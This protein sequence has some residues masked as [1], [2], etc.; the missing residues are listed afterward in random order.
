MRRSCPACKEKL[1]APGARHA[2]LACERCRAEYHKK[3]ECSGLTKAQVRVWATSGRWACSACSS[4]QRLDAANQPGATRAADPKRDIGTRDKL[5]ILQWNVDG[6][7]T[8]EV[9]LL[10]FIDRDPNI[11]VIL[12]QESKL[13][14]SDKTPSLPGYT[15]VRRDRPPAPGGAGAGSRGGGLITFVKKDIAFRPTKAYTRED[16][17]GQLEAQAVEIPLSPGGQFTVVN[18]YNP[19]VR[20]PVNPSSGVQFLRVPV[21][22][23]IVAGDFNAHSPLWDDASQDADNWGEELE[24][25]I[26]DHG[27]ASLNDGSATH[28]NRATGSGGSPDVTLVHSSAVGGCVWQRQTISGSDHYPLLCEVDVTP[29]CLAESGQR[30]LK[31]RLD[32]ADWA[33][34]ATEME[35]RVGECELPAR[36][37]LSARVNFVTYAMT[38]AARVHVGRYRVKRMGRSWI[39]PELKLATQRRNALGRR[40][41]DNRVAWLEACREVRRLSI[42]CKRESWRSYVERIGRDGNCSSTKVWGVIH[43]LSGKYSAPA[44]EN[45]MLEHRGRTLASNAR[46]A[47]AFVQHYAAVSRHKS[48][49]EDRKLERSVKERLSQSRRSEGTEGVGP[50][51]ADFSMEEM[52]VALKAGKK[53]GAEGP[54]E[55][56]PL[57]LRNLGEAGREYVLA[58]FNQSWREGVCPQSWRDACI[59]PLLKPGKPAG[60]LASYRP[61]A[62][63]SCLGKVME[64]MVS[65]RLQHLAESHGWLCQEQSGFRPQRSAEDQV[66]RLSQAVSDGFQQSP[67]LRTVLATLDFSKAYDMVWRADLYD[68]MLRKGVPPR[69]VRWLKGFLTNRQARVRLGGGVSK[70][71]LFREGLPQGSVLS[72]LLF[73]F[74][75]NGLRQRLP[76]G[77]E[78]SM[79]A[80]DVALWASHRDKAVAAAKVEE[81]VGVVF[82]WSQEKKLMLNLG[83]CEVSFFSTD[84][85]EAKWQPCVKVGATSLKFT[86]NPVFL[87][88]MYDRTLSFRPQAERTAA[89]LSKKTRLLSALAGS[90]WGWD[91]DLLRRIFQSVLL[92]SSSYCGAGWK[93]WAAKSTL[94]VLDKAQNRGLRR[95]TGQFSS[96]PI[97]ALRMEA[98]FQSADCYARRETALAWEKSL[99]LPQTH[100]RKSV[101]SSRVRHRLQR[102][103]W[104]KEGKA[105]ADECGFGAHAPL[106]LPP[107]TTASWGRRAPRWKV[108]LSLEG[109]SSRDAPAE[110]KC[111]D[112][113]TTIRSFGRRK[114]IIY[115]DGSAEGGV[116]SGGSAAII[117]NDDPDDPRVLLRLQQTGPA[118]TSSF[119]T[120]VWALILAVRWLRDNGAAEDRFLICSDSRS[121]LSALAGTV[122]KPH[123]LMVGLRSE[124]DRV[125]SLVDLQWIP[126][127]CGLSGNELADAEAG[128]SARLDPGRA[129]PGAPLSLESVRSAISSQIVDAQPDPVRRREVCQVYQGRKGSTQGLS[130]K[131]EVMLAQMRSGQ[132][133]L[134]STFRAKILGEDPVCP[135]CNGSEET[136]V[137]F[138]QECPA[139]EALR[140]RLFETFP[141]PLSVLWTHPRESLRYCGESNGLLG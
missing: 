21:A 60:E 131:E 40:I 119:E 133:K 24:T 19:P 33:G 72:P 111:A 14:P 140:R 114:A 2:P 12:A 28:V 64:R 44:G 105:L 87:G 47:D 118:F 13:I 4:Q 136:L 57:F 97:E 109:G 103:S 139:T 88:V 93:P 101:A 116:R 106:E 102:S 20:G 104:R 54:D 79:Y 138:M 75:I 67:P 69:Y 98:G 80:D 55:I 90:E 112:A 22:P 137:H 32:T 8:A 76:P 73:L 91:G 70:P 132:S 61:I 9:D 124:L 110:V 49:R 56:A 126:G 17:V 62:L 27:L 51:C 42:V 36:A 92:G 121:A 7:G 15:A 83:K 65:V 122:G 48:S 43:S 127:H 52:L 135:K 11:D 37:T 30:K 129:P 123:S 82:R 1:K 96:T 23:F 108:H 25:W 85:H 39:T 5:R 10:G 68:T 95:V 120:E 31:W 50:E 18:V 86:P 113:L 130:R 74:V 45:V 125:P 71:R 59:V 107:P 3:R 6:V 78:V 41:A 38:Q 99:R 128:R 84:T 16:D 81:A 89:S 134:L 100:P 66:L 46:K 94:G 117:C 58:C 34:Y 35:Q 115:T 26:D 141:P 29:I 63:T 53:K 77:V